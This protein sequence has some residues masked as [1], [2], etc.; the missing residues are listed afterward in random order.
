I[1]HA[2]FDSLLQKHVSEDGF[3]NYKG[4]IRDSVQMNE[5]LTLLKNNHPNKK[6]WSKDEQLAYW[7]NAYNAFTV[8]LIMNH[9]P[10]ESI[11]DIKSGIGFINS[12]WDIK[13][14]K[15]EGQEYD[16]NN[17]EHSIIR[18]QFNE[19]RIHFAVNCASYSCPRLR[20]EAYTA[21]NLE[22]QLDD[23]ARTFFNDERK[24][25]IVSEDQIVLSS[26][27]KWYSTDFTQKGIFSRLFGGS[28]R[29]KKLIGFVNPYVETTINEEAEVTFM[30][31]SWALNEK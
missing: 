3:V 4:F 13:F 31:Y 28:G 1:N 7:I 16:L 9:Y 20:N 15:I 27:L 22:I 23:Q 25:K 10:V 6:N 14:F 8:K 11:K 30:E 17:I 19:P 18:K 5:Y 2:L 24:N 26:L 21:K 29:S 12:V